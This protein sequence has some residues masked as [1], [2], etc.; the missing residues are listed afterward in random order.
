MFFKRALKQSFGWAAVLSAPFRSQAA[1]PTACILTYHRVAEVGFIDPQ[2]DDWNVLPTTFA[3]QIAALAEAVEFVSLTDLR[4]RLAAPSHGGKP[5]VCVTFDDGYANV[6]HQALPV[7]QRYRVPATIFLV[8]KYI[9]S[10]LPLPFDR[11]S[12]K[13]QQR[14]SRHTWRAL[15]WKEIETCLKS[16]LITVGAHSHQHLDGRNCS[17][18]QMVDEAA[19]SHDILLQTCGTQHAEAYSY[20]YGSTRL[21]EVS[22]AYVRA[23]RQSGFRLAV[24]TDL[25]LVKKSS[26]PLLLPRVEA[27]AL[28][29][30][31]VLRA[32]A[33]GALAPFH[34]TDRLRQAARVG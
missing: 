1:Q 18:A 15:N 20:P 26:H 11:W 29:S 5:L 9:G 14:V 3:Q 16:G 12:H 31:A 28:D 22:P 2:L 6:L 32:K 17:V 13:N 23:V 7:L 27:H 24:T 21:G 34:V 33:I 30:G 8:T 10:E 4:A 25:G 19:Q